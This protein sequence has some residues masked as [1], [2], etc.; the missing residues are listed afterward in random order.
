MLAPEMPEPMMTMSAVLG[1][2]LGGIWKGSFCQD[3]GVGVDGGKLGVLIREVRLSNES[4]DSVSS[5][6]RACRV[7]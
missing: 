4:L 6:L 5:S 3:E 1:S 7:E 2:V